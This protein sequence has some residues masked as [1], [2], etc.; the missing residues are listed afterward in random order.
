MASAAS[1]DE[2]FAPSPFFLGR[3]ASPARPPPMM[4][5]TTMT[6]MTTPRFVLRN[7][8]CRETQDPEAAAAAAAAAGSGF[9]GGGA[10]TASYFMLA[11]VR[12]FVWRRNLTVC[13]ARLCCSM[14]Q[15][16][17]VN[18]NAHGITQHPQPACLPACPA[19]ETLVRACK[20]VRFPGSQQDVLP[21]IRL[22]NFPRSQTI[23]P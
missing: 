23:V 4:T 9:A 19:T 11:M 18:M 13:N 6:V 17:V 16:F 8:K 21:K 12:C 10:S 3:A 2:P 22:V 5:R 7:G 15:R 14:S 20:A 1:P